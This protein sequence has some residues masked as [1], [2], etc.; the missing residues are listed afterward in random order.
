MK[1]NRK[2]RNYR[3]RGGSM[4]MQRAIQDILQY[5]LMTLPLRSSI[6]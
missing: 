2:F 1:D 5:F 4:L 6:M 3:H